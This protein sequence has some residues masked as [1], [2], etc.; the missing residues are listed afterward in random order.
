MYRNKGRITKDKGR[1]L[2]F[3]FLSQFFPKHSP[4]FPQVMQFFPQMYL[5]FPQ[6][7]TIGDG[8]PLNLWI[9]DKTTQALRMRLKL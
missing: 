8:F 7:V 6:A 5:S 2:Q 4:L 1:A 9:S 3:L